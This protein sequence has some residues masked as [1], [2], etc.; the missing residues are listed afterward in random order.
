[1]E[2]DMENDIETWVLYGFRRDDQLHIRLAS[3]TKGLRQRNNV[4]QHDLG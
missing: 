4:M 3:G 1:M 2:K